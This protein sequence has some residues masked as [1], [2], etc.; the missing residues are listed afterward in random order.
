M[1]TIFERLK[2]FREVVFIHS[3]YM[4]LEF[5]NAYLLLVWVVAVLPTN[6]SI[7][8]TG[9]AYS[10]LARYITENQFGALFLLLMLNSFFSMINGNLKYRFVCNTIQT[11]LYTALFFFM[12]EG[13]SQTPAGVSTLAF[14]IGGLA[15]FSF[16]VSARLLRDVHNHVS[17]WTL[18]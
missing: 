5:A 7:F 3:D 8:A 18:S 2:E 6:T 11:I 14:L 17:S 15:L 1:R 16:I 12:L 4:M 9:K 10:V 13:A